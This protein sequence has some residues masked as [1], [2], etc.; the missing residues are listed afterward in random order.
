M[1]R[2]NVEL[3]RRAIEAFNRRDLETWLEL[4]DERVEFVPLNLELE[5]G[6]YRDHAGV[7]QF[8]A[9][10]LSVFPDFT[11]EADEV[12]DLGEV[13]LALVRLR[14]H[15]TSSDVPFEQ[16]IWQVV[17]WR[18]QKCVSWH[19]FRNESAALEAAGLSE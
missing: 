5:G 12:R 1:S 8:W 7:R 6:S 19:T 17:R 18:R 11:V 14:G 4:A 15:G 13:T 16:P 10:Y 3:H 9:D 2:E